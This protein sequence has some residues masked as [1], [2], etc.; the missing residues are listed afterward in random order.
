MYKAIIY[1]SLSDSVF[2]DV[3]ME[4]LA[5]VS[6]D[7]DIRNAT[8]F[9]DNL[10]KSNSM[11]PSIFICDDKTARDC[12]FDLKTE[13]AVIRLTYSPDPEGGN[14]EMLQEH[15]IFAYKGA[16]ETASVIAELVTCMRGEKIVFREE[17]EIPEII[18]VFSASG[19]AGTTSIAAAAAGLI[20]IM[21]G[22]KALYI[23]YG[24]FGREPLNYDE[25]DSCD[26]GRGSISR[27]LYY[28]GKNRDFSIDSYISEKNGWGILKTG[29]FNPVYTSITPEVLEIIGKKAA[30]EWG[31]SYLVVDIGARADR[32]GMELIK[33]SDVIM[34]VASGEGEFIL[35]K[36]CSIDGEC[37]GRYIRV[38][39][40]WHGEWS[41]EQKGIIYISQYAALD[42]NSLDTGFGT[43]A[44]AAVKLIAEGR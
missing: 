9:G 15:V 4:R 27:M 1:V 26:K 37:S 25:K 34:E 23:R 33:A 36:I 40:R 12:P 7:L 24:P 20:P 44:G 29:Y 14:D 5:S 19:G 43:E 21:Y 2:Q 18:T 10:Y 17:D 8:D 6:R 41:E 31:A 13:T 11:T 22:E 30:S 32:N 35:D 28:I 3:F 39:N 16:R 38:R 42:E